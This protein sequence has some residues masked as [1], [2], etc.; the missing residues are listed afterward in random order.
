MTIVK[1]SIFWNLKMK[2][3]DQHWKKQSRSITSLTILLSTPLNIKQQQTWNACNAMMAGLGPASKHQ[4]RQQPA[5]MSYVLLGLGRYN[6]DQNTDKHSYLL[7]VRNITW[8]QNSRE[9]CKIRKACNSLELGTK[10]LPFELRSVNG[11]WGN[12]LYHRSMKVVVIY[13]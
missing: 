1:H 7:L 6:L 11:Y 13:F 2:I 8:W 4:S 9:M 3:N 10:L 12:F 5:G